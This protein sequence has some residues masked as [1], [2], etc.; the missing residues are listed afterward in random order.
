M[1]AWPKASAGDCAVTSCPQ[2]ERPGRAAPDRQRSAMRCNTGGFFNP[3]GW[4]RAGGRSGAQT[5]GWQ[6]GIGASWR[7]ARVLRPLRGR[8]EIFGRLSRGCRS[9]LRCAPAR[10]AALPPAVWQASSLR[11]QR[12]EA[13]LSLQWTRRRCGVCIS[14]R[15]GGAPLSICYLTQGGA[16]S[17]LALGWY[18]AALSERR[19]R[20]GW[21]NTHRAREGWGGVLSRAPTLR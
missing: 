20:D 8:C 2:I 16:R 6:S 21:W 3:E 4:Q 18:V 14:T 12:S 15:A 5:P 7:D 11:G 17:S 9:R 1:T 19:R 10:Q 13:E